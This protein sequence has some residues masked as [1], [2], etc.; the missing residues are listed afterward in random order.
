MSSKKLYFLLIGL[1]CLLFAGLIVGTF[2][3]NSLLSKKASDL[4]KTKAKSIALSQEQDSLAKAKKDLKKYED[5]HTI[6]KSVVPED[7]NQAEVVRELVKIADKNKVS[8]ASITFPASTLGGTSSGSTAAGT[9]STPTSAAATSAE[10]LSQLKPV[11]NIPGVY[12]LTI[13]VVSDSKKPVPYNQFV[14]FLED[15]EHNRR[16][17]QVNTITLEPNSDNRNLLS[18]TLTLN[19]YIKP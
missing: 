13:T 1:V 17:A 8:L 14:R 16:T 5:L 10:A 3:I 7:K 19:A 9:S 15:L 6:T 18:F 2:Q 12:N 11:T 4:T